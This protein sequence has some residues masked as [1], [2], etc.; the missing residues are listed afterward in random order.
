MKYMAFSSLRL[1]EAEWNAPM[2]VK[3]ARVE[4]KTAAQVALR[5]ILQQGV[6]IVTSSRS[7][8]HMRES[9]AATHFRLTSG[10]MEQLS[11][12]RL[13]LREALSNGRRST[14][15]AFKQAVVGKVLLLRAEI[16]K[17]ALFADVNP[18]CSL[19][20]AWPQLR[21]VDML[22]ALHMLALSPKPKSF[23]RFFGYKIAADQLFWF[24]SFINVTLP[25]IFGMMLAQTSLRTDDLGASSQHQQTLRQLQSLQ[26]SEAGFYAPYE[27]ALHGFF[28]FSLSNIRQ[29]DEV[30]WANEWCHTNSSLSTEPRGQFNHVSQC[31]HGIGHAFLYRL[32]AVYTKKTGCQLL[33]RGHIPEAIIASAIKLCALTRAS[34][35]CKG[36]V[37]M[38]V[39]TSTKHADRGQN[40]FL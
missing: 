1:T 35:A 34:E 9:L 10:E 11:Q 27:S 24:S 12:S 21:R 32:L 4:N 17:G 8:S 3:V 36:G 19:F 23:Q 38:D 5:W 14:Y 25:H 30:F 7:I 37:Y 13:E 28:T 39:K 29:L 18:L 33:N 26:I 6:A 2:L 40:I 31:W 22:H 20:A 16:K 15:Y